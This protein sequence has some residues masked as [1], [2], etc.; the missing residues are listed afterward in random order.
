VTYFNSGSDAGTAV[1]SGSIDAT[2]IGPGPATSLY[3]QSEGSVA[4]VSG[5]TA[6][7][8]SFVVRKDAGIDSPEDLAGKRI[9]VPGLGNTQDVALRTWLHEHALRARDEGGD[10]SVAAVDNPELVGLFR[11]GH[12]DGAWEPEPYPSLLIAE[13]LAEPFVDEAELWPAGEFVTTVLLV[14]RTYMEANPDVVADLVTANVEA[15][16][17]IQDDP[18]TAKAA[19]QAGLIKAGAPSLDQ[20]VVDTAWD[21]LTF[22][23]DPV[24]PSLIQGAANAYSLGYLDAEPSAMTELF[25]LDD[26]NDVLTGLDVPLIQVVAS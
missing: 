25:R 7:G 16:Q 11:A 2:Y 4:I 13:G 10:V 20:A 5:V 24:A 6:G 17:L 19:A 21:N 8:A 14:N 23:W 12:L 9:A 22:T 26:L 18:E 1:L 3:L 15:I